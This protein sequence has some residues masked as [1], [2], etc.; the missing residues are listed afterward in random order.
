MNAEDNALWSA[1]YWRNPLEHGFTLLWNNASDYG[2]YWQ[3]DSNDVHGEPMIDLIQ[4]RL[5]P[6]SPAIDSGNPQILDKD[7]TRSDIGPFGGPWAY[8][9]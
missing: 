7:S 4:G 2:T 9:Y 8:N 6:G 1:S 5:L 3:P